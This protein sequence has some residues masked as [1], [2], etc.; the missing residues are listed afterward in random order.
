M[1]YAVGNV[2]VAVSWSDYFTGLLAKVNI[3]FLGIHGINIPAW[4][5]IDYTSAHN[6][7]VDAAAKLAT[8]ADLAALN[9]A[10]Q[11]SYL[12]WTQAPMLGSFRLIADLPAVFIVLLITALIYRGIKETRNASNAMV[13]IKVTIVLLVILLGIFYVDTDNWNPFYQMELQAFFQVF[14]QCSLP[15]LDLTPFLQRLKNAK[16]R[17]AIYREVSCILS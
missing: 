9:M 15:T 8:G 4:A 11:T 3:P 1:E 14:R 13:A 16:I 5:S 10:Q 17:S 7:F 2:V 12:A 6:G